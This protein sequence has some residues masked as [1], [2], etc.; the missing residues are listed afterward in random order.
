VFLDFAVTLLCGENIDFWKR[1]KDFQA[2]LD[3]NVVIVVVLFFC[4]SNF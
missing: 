3:P 4:C 2:I 1:V